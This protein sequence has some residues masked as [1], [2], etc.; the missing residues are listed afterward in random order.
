MRKIQPK[1]IDELQESYEEDSPELQEQLGEG[2]EAY[3]RGEGTNA[4]E[5]LAQL[6]RE[7][8]VNKPKG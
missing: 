6:E 2:Y 5:F 4:E 1:D 7:L 8:E 3:L